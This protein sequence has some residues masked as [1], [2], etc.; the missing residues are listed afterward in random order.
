LAILLYEKKI[1]MVSTFFRI[2]GDLGFLL[3]DLENRNTINSIAV[4][5][6]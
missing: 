1:K 5:G 2:N 3:V 6:S 4:T